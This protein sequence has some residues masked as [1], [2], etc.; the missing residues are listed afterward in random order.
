M[1]GGIFLIQ[2]GD[3]L[4]ELNEQPYEAEEVL[5]RLLADHP[6]ILAG[7]Q[8]DPATPRRWLLITREA[9]IPSEEGGS[10]R[11]ALDHLFLDQDAVPTLVE[12]KRSSDTRTRREVVGQMLDYAAN[13]VVYW[14]TE[15]I[16]AQ[17]ETS[18]TLSG[19]DADEVLSGFLDP[20]AETEVF[21]QAARQNL[22]AQRIRLVFVADVI[23]PELR[24][25]VEF[26]NGQMNP[27]EVI[28]VEVRQFI[29][30][31]V[32]A[33]VPRVLG[34]TAAAQQAKASVSSIG[35]RVWDEDS[36]FADLAARRGPHEAAVA[37]EI[38]GWARDA[39]L[40]LVWS[41]GPKE[42]S[43]Y[44]MLDHA[45]NTHW[46]VVLWTYG[47]VEI[48]FQHLARQ[49][50]YATHH[51]PFLDDTR[52]LDLLRRFNEVPGVTILETA[53]GGR[54]S[55]PFSALVDEE[56]RRRFLAVL[57]WL[58]SELRADSSRSD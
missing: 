41:G 42:G 45:G 49:H 52:R 3:Q 37:R 17:F 36:F 55:V 7:D 12:V 26:L 2:E 38:L 28:A 31:G 40:R 43:V 1:A 21:W 24:R 4:I 57:D 13:A 20:G 35:K 32:R 22:Q 29:G 18:C 15:T 19:R 56:A 30:Q 54:P 51:H 23:P 10:G 6:N 11:W 47:R 46:T 5:Q 53:I 34:Q 58:V 27:A 39:E 8:I 48:Q 44:L 9:A 33:L 25:I 14:P 16:R 50:S